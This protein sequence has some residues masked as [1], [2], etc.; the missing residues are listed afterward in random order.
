MT[1]KISITIVHTLIQ[2]L[3]L[4][5]LSKVEPILNTPISINDFVDQIDQPPALIVNYFDEIMS[6]IGFVLFSISF[7]VLRKMMNVVYKDKVENKVYFIIGAIT[8]FAA[9]CVFYVGIKLD[10]LYMRHGGF[11]LVGE[12]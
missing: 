7:I 2:L 8:S 10:E 4:I 6:I 3:P 9:M 1:K 12:N 5:V 11:D